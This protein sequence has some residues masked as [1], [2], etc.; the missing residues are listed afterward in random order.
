MQYISID[1]ETTGLDRENHQVIE[2]GAIIE[3]TLDQKDFDDI[4][5]FHA[6][7][8]HDEYRGSAYAI[9]LNQRIFSILA[10]RERFKD[11]DLVAYDEKYNIIHV[12]NVA[13]AFYNWLLDNGYGNKLLVY[14][15][16]IKLVCAGKNF[17]SFDAIYLNKLPKFKNLIRFGHRIVDPATLYTDFISDDDVASLETCL[18]RAG[19]ETNVTHDAVLDAWDVIRVL[20]PKYETNK[21][22]NF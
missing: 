21:F 13:D 16:P 19:F 20:R 18:E 14:R 11:D 1:I 5:K 7:V 9:N 10:R 12:D 3:D 15:E 17:A 6:I 4:P 8:R 22:V 2:I